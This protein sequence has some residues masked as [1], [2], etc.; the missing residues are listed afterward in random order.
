[1]MPF[2]SRWGVEAPQHDA[3]A[4]ALLLAV[5]HML[6]DV[7][8][9]KVGP[10]TRV[11]LGTFVDPRFKVCVC[12][13]VCVCVR[14]RERERE[15]LLVVGRGGSEGTREM[16]AL[17]LMHT[18][19]LTPPPPQGGRS[20][21]RTTRDIVHVVEVGGRE[22]LWY[23][24]PAAIHVALLRGSTADT[25]GNVSMEREALVGDQLHQVG[26]CGGGEGRGAGQAPRCR[27]ASVRQW[28]V[29]RAW[30]AQARF[31]AGACSMQP[32]GRR[33]AAGSVAHHALNPPHTHQAP[34]HPPTYTHTHTHS[35]PCRPWQ[36]TTL[37]GW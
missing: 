12:V 8:A 24:A 5:S 19:A 15:S 29:L 34:T 28:Q 11:G 16:C 21:A 23:E 32:A 9:G 33:V 2:S 26:V 7:A 10:I 35:T 27:P 14:E 18:H 36:R 20:N 37:A 13:C 3:I 1:M 17:L 31:P 22:L 30:G 6:R 25:H 4:P